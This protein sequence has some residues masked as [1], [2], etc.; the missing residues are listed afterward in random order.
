MIVEAG[1]GSRALSQGWEA[2]RLG[3]LVLLLRAV[4]DR[5]ELTCP[6]EML[7]YGALVLESSEELIEQL[8][9]S[10]AELLVNAAIRRQP[11]TR[12]SA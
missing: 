4:L 3:R 6:R 12:M 9:A 5:T 7:N 2:L 10:R 11:G 1:D 8:A